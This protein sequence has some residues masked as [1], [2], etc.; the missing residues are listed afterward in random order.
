MF[1]AIL[2][3]KGPFFFQITHS[4]S[5]FFRNRHF[6]SPFLFKTGCPE[7]GRPAAL[8]KAFLIILIAFFHDYD[9]FN[10]DDYGFNGFHGDFNGDFNVK[11]NVKL[12]LK[13]T[14]PTYFWPASWP[15]V[16][17]FGPSPQFLVSFVHCTGNLVMNP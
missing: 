6:K 17:P 10:N 14:C 13:P 4:Y 1:N 11:F 7:D 3:E 16:G 2:N 9:D 8:K 12:N 15:A 5:H